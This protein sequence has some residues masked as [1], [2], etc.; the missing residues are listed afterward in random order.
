MLKPKTHFTVAE[1]LAMEAVSE[2]KNEYWDGIIVPVHQ[3]VV[4]MAGASLRHAELVGELL[5][6]FR[7][8]LRGRCRAV[9]SDLRVSTGGGKYLYPDVVVYCGEPELTEE[10]P[11][12]LLNPS[13]LVEVT[14]PSTES[15]DTGRKLEAYLQIPSLQEYWVARQD[16]A[17]IT[18]Y[19][20]DGAEW[21]LRIEGGQ[22]AVIQSEHL[23]IT[24]ALADIYPG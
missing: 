15:E 12:A 4:G 10:N 5:A 6:E 17:S 18:Q 1:Y 3:E 13:L 14:S 2:T 24:L 21:R 20:R 23:G 16:T 11:P 19:V 8:R 22:D 7:I 9:A